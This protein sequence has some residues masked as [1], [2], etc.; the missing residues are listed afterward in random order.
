MEKKATTMLDLQAD[1]QVVWA[2]RFD[3]SA[4]D[5]LSVQEEVAGE[6]A[7]QIDPVMLLIQA[8]RGAAHPEAGT[9]ADQLILGSVLLITRPEQDGFMRA[10]EQLAR[11][12]ALEPDHP[13]AHA[14]YAAW[15][16]LLIS[17]GWAIDPRQASARAATLAERAIVLDPFSAAAYTVAGHVRHAQ[18]LMGSQ[19]IVFPAKLLQPSLQIMRSTTP[20]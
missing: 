14:W 11:A 17:Q 2:R 12:I 16:V 13:S 20:V 7:A 1:N 15:H 19:V 6:V 8:R 5:L 4:D 3:R 9:S 10:G 18:R